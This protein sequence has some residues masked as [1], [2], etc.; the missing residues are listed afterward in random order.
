MV[1]RP[2][3]NPSPNPVNSNQNPNPNPSPNL[4]HTA[5]GGAGTE[6]EA[7]SDRVGVLTK[8]QASVEERLPPLIYPLPIP[9][10]TLRYS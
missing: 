2:N 6:E 4:N 8:L 10:L 5:P 7:A 9:N 3:P 1:R